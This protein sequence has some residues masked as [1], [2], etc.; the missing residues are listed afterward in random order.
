MIYEDRTDALLGCTSTAELAHKDSKTVMELLGKGL[1]RN[2]RLIANSALQNARCGLAAVA[3]LKE[4]AGD[5]LTD[6]EQAAIDAVMAVQKEAADADLAVK[7]ATK[8]AAG[9]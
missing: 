4:F 1:L 9:H 3:E 8:K 2:V 5:D 7:E 6:E